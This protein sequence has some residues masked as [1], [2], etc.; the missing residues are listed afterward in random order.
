MKACLYFEHQLMSQIRTIEAT[1]LKSTYGYTIES[2]K[3]DDLVHLITSMSADFSQATVPMSWA[4]DIVP[5]LKYLP[6]SFPGFS[7]KKTAAR[8]RK[9]M[10]QSAYVPYRFVQRQMASGHFANSFVSNLVQKYKT[11]DGGGS[12]NLSEEDELAII[13][14]A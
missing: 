13:W 12:P 10:R 9:T 8:F 11:D 14:A 1:I 5:I 2:G 3:P 4:P 7:F 6:E